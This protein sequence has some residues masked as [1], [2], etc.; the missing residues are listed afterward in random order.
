MR[1]RAPVAA[2]AAALLLSLGASAARAATLSGRLLHPDGRPAAGHTL[3]VVGGVLSVTCA[4][5]GSFRLEPAPAVPFQL[6]ATGP[7]GEVSAP[8]EVADAR[9]RAARAGDPDVV[10]DSVTVVSGVA[11]ASTCCPASAA[12]VLSTEALEQRPPQR[13][14]DSLDVRRRRL[15]ARRGRRT[16]CRRCAAWAEAAR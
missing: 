3:S 8:I 12:T 7:N 10:R 13:L 14:V 9:R 1:H 2:L 16:A 4:E 5:D 15:E 11:P 6:V